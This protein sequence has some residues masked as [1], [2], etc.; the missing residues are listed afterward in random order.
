MDDAL[1]RGIYDRPAVSD[2]GD[3]VQVTSA[4]HLI[5]GA[6]VD[7]STRDLSFSGAGGG[8]GAGGSVAGVTAN[9][10]AVNTPGATQDV[11]GASLGSTVPASGTNATTGVGGATAGGVGGGAGGGSGVGP[12][13]ESLP[14][15]G[16]PAAAVGALGA[17]LAAAG[18]GLRRVLRLR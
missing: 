1:G 16:F 5:Y 18:A 2:F 14:F 17:G 11:A 10:P 8:G 6:S 4:M 3:L 13:G 9:S 12:G 15:T 7:P